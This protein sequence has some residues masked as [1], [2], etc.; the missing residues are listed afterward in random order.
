MERFKFK[1]KADPVKYSSA[2]SECIPPVRPKRCWFN[3]I[4]PQSPWEVRICHPLYTAL[5]CQVDLDPQGWRLFRDLCVCVCRHF[6]AALFTFIKG[7]GS[8]WI[9][10]IAWRVI[11]FF[12]FQS[13]LSC[14]STHFIGFVFFFLWVGDWSGTEV[15]LCIA[16]TGLAPAFA[17]F[18]VS[19]L[20]LS[21]RKSQLLW[22]GTNLM[23]GKVVWKKVMNF[24][25]FGNESWPHWMSQSWSLVVKDTGAIYIQTIW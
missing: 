24:D 6:F 23:A 4:W 9:F 12:S 20:F 16:F 22:F 7:L 5:Y 19:S 17:C 25:T 1:G 3:S 18:L 11:T 13:S 8:S 15:H 10:H 2:K 21:V 14:I